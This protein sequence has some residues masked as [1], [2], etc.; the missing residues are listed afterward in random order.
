MHVFI[1]L[2]RNA[3]KAGSVAGGRRGDRQLPTLE[4]EV[5]GSAALVATGALCGEVLNQAVVGEALFHA[6]HRA[7]DHGSVKLTDVLAQV[8]VDAHGGGPKAPVEPAQGRVGVERQDWRCPLF[9]VGGQIG[10]RVPG[11]HECG[12]RVTFQRLGFEAFGVPTHGATARKGKKLRA[13]GQRNKVFGAQGHQVVAGA[14]HAAQGRMLLNLALG[15]GRQGKG[16][17]GGVLDGSCAKQGMLR[18]EVKT[19]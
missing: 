19:A 13:F 15:I 9:L 18:G 5:L 6:V 3:A 10:L 7:L 17:L 11:A 16:D 1:F 2:Q 4:K 14:S 12:Y 8:G